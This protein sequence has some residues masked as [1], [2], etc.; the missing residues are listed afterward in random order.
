MAAV[1]QK[2]PQ[3]LKKRQS[4]QASKVVSDRDL[5]KGDTLYMRQ[6][7]LKNNLLRSL[8]LLL[9]HFFKFYWKWVR[10]LMI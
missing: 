3:I 2:M 4:I 6:D 8:K 5:L 1:F 10:L 9:D 7:L